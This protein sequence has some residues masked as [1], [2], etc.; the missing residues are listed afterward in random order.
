MYSGNSE[1]Y[2]L[3]VFLNINFFINIALSIITIIAKKYNEAEINPEFSSKKY[4]ANNAIIGSFALHGING[5][6]I[7]VI[8]LSSSFSTILV[9][10]I[11]G[12][13][14]PEPTINGIKLLPLN[15][16]LLNNLHLENT[17]VLQFV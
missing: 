9:P 7:V 16:I 1:I 6:N 12:T 2:V 4:P 13:E 17:V 5:V 11:P 15:P 10:I 3:E 8:F 14:H